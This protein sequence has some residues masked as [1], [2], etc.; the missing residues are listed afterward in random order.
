MRTTRP[1]APRP[2]SIR[3]LIVPA[4]VG[5]LGLAGPP[6]RASYV[7]P[8][9][10]RHAMVVSTSPI[11][12]RVGVDILEHGGNAADAAAAVALAL[13][14]V[15]PS[16]GNLGGGGFLLWRGADGQAEVIDYRERAPAAATRDMYLDDKGQIVAGASTTGYRAVGVPGTP[17]GLQMM[18]DRHGRM[19]AR[20]K[21]LVEPAL[22]LAQGG[23][24]VD[25]HLARSLRDADKLLAR[26]PDSARIFMK[27]GQ[28]LAVGD[29]LVQVDLARTLALFAE[30]GPARAFYGGPVGARLVQAVAAGGGLITEADLAEYRAVV[31][32]PLVGSYRGH[33]IITVPSPS[34]GGTLLLEELGILEHF[35]LPQLAFHSADEIH[36]LVEAMRRAFADRSTLLGD[37]DFV[38]VPLRGLTSRGYLDARA[39]TVNAQMATPSRAL[40][41][42]D[43][44]PFEPPETTHFTIVDAD[45]N[46]VSNTYTLNGSFGCGAVAAGTGILLN[47]EMDDFASKP[48]VPNVYG[49]VQGEANAIAP[50]KRPL[51]TMTPTIVLEGDKVLFAIGSPGG[52]TIVNTVLQIIINILDHH[53]NLREAIEAPR[54]HHQFLPDLI[55]VEKWGLSPETRAALSARGHLF[56]PAESP[57][58]PYIGDAHGIAIDPATSVRLGAADPRLGGAAIGY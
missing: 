5:A 42:S 11:A 18:V 47:N 2:G 56:A 36:F 31:R 55:F 27:D 49:L 13:A 20:W 14:V 26:F 19:G 15:W 9:A 16:A 35:A 50:R 12:S 4:L 57:F 52:P 22:R 51:S 34:S 3:R 29:R 1:P 48:G 21:A 40:P 58:P 53:M 38:K 8:V 7:E 10:A 32:A 41:A 39:A 46:V 6:A 25:G 23:F 28:P 24:V 17:A 44:W 45:G 54:L 33:T 37:A 43:P 30:R